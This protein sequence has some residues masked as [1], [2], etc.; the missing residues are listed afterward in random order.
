MD[1]RLRMKPIGICSILVQYTTFQMT[2]GGSKGN[3]RG[4]QELPRASHERPGDPNRT[5]GD[6]KGTPGGQN[7]TPEGPNGRPEG[8]KWQ[9]VVPERP[10]NV[11]KIINYKMGVFKIEKMVFMCFNRKMG[12]S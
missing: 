12:T 6:P 5:P 2:L 4:G 7:G 3:P 11:N 10:Q 8:S 1:P 9:P